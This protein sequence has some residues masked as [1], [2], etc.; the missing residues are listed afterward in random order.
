MKQIKEVIKRNGAADV[1]F[2][3]FNQ[4]DVINHRLERALPFIPQTV[5]L[6]IVPYY[7]LFCDNERTVSAYALA[8]DYH[9]LLNRISETSITELKLLFPEAGFIAFADHSPINEKLA[10]AKAGLGIIGDH[11]LLITERFSSFVFIFEIFTDLV[12]D[13][14][15]NEVKHCEHCGAC[16]KACP[17][18]F[19]DKATCLSAITQKKGELSEEETLLIKRS[20]C[21]WGCDLCQMVCPHTKK[22]ISEQTIYTD[23][24]WFNTNIVAVPDEQTIANPDDFP[25]RAYSWRGK[26]TIARNISI[27]NDDSQYK[28]P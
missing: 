17:A 22:A 7:T 6:G 15:E 24:K 3:A 4:C 8:H 27:L 14:P 13:L 5:I 9:T 20:G 21:V 26:Q 12:F 28:I 1:G 16:K 23:S 18:N 10:A 25:L 19:Y 2:V 11:S